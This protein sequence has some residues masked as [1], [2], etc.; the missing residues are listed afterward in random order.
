MSRVCFRFDVR[1]GGFG[2]IAKYRSFAGEFQEIDFRG[3]S[4]I[5][6]F[7]MRFLESDYRFISIEVKAILTMLSFWAFWVSSRL[8]I[9]SKPIRELL[10]VGFVSRIPAR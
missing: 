3:F 10:P 4:L 5:V 6:L 2:M 1:D 7:P 8:S 9:L